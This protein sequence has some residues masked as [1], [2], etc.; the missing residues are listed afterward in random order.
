[1][2]YKHKLQKI[3]KKQYRTYTAHYNKADSSISSNPSFKLAKLK[4]VN[5]KPCQILTFTY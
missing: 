5:S 1:M 3:T 4:S 2:A